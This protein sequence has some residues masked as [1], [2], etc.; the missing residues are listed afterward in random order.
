MRQLAAILVAGAVWGCSQPPL[1]PDVSTLYRSSFDGIEVI[2]VATFDASEGR[3]YN[4]Q[5]CEIVRGLMEGQ[6][7]I[8]PVRY[9]CAPGR[10]RKP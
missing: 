7:V 6:R 3:E 9:W 1:D 2:H 5:N 8:A 10:Y 4:L